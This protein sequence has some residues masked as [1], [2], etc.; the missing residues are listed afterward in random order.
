MNQKNKENKTRRKTNFEH[1]RIW[2]EA[3]R[4]MLIVHSIVNNLPSSEFRTTDQAKRSSSSVPDNIAE[5]TGSYYYKDKLKCLNVSRKE[6][7][8]TQN[9]LLSIKSKRLYSVN[10]IDKLVDRYQGLIIGINTYKQKVTHSM[11]DYN[12]SKKVTHI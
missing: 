1:L 3:H 8:E 12:K 4:L 11:E 2:Q 10:Q 7:V 9:H 5:A 6:A